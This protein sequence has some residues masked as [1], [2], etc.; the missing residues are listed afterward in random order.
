MKTKQLLLLSAAS[1]LIGGGG[2]A[3]ISQALANQPSLVASSQPAG[4]RE[5][6]KGPR[7]AEF[8]ERLG[9]TEAQQTQLR[10]IH[11]ASHQQREAIPTAEQKAQMQ[12]IR[13]NAKT[14]MDAVLTEQ[15]RQQLQQTTPPSG[16]QSRGP[17]FPRIS[18]LTDEQRAQLRQI[19]ESTH[20]Q[21]DTVL[22]SEQRSRL[23][24]IRQDTKS[25]MDAVLTDQQRQQLE[26]L[27]QQK[28]QNR[29][30]Q[31]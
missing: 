15:Q 27:R 4:P 29:Q 17:G 9:L 25:K 6:W 18:G 28:Q 21:M 26:Q 20:Q 11:E 2:F 10:Q 23:E 22:T 7:S 19:H 31:S 24:A 13:A 12:T 1:V 30:Q 3:A 5:G 8:A 16:G 14:K